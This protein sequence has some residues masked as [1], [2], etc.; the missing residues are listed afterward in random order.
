M[1]PFQEELL[2]RHLAAL[3]TDHI[4]PGSTDVSL[5]GQHTSR[6]AGLTGVTTVE[7]GAP[8]AAGPAPVVGPLPARRTDRDQ[9][10]SGARFAGPAADRVWVRGSSRAGCWMSCLP[11]QRWAGSLTRP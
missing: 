8:T 7:L 11:G 2:A 4:P 6:P 1:P 3:T 9:T 10:D 5:L